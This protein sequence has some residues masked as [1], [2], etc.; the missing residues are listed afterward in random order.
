MNQ[1]TELM[2]KLPLLGLFILLIVLILL[3]F[4]GNKSF[5][6]L[7]GLTG[8]CLFGLSLTFYD[9]YATL[10]IG[11][12]LSQNSNIPP[13]IGIGFWLS[14]AYLINSLIKKYI[15]PRRLTLEGDSK[16][17]LLLQ[18]LVTLT[19]YIIAVMIIIGGVYGQSITGIAAA[20]GAVAL[21]LGYTAR[22]MV[23]EIFAGIAI[24]INAPFEKGDLIQMNEEWGFVKDIDWRT[25]TY[26]DMDNNYVVVP[27][28]TVAASK[29]RNLDRPSKMVRRTLYFRAEYNVPPKIIVEE[30]DAA[31]NECP[32]IA[33]HPWNFTSFF[34]TDETGMRYKLHFY[35]NHYDDWYVASDELFNAIWYRFARK[36]IRFAHQRHL[37][38]KNKDDE[39]KGLPDS[40]YD[41][42]NWRLLVERFNQVPMFE[43]MTS[44]DTE[45]IAK[46]AKV[47][48]VGPPEKIIRAG[49]KRTSMFLIAQGSAEVFEVDENGK[50]T[51]MAEVGVSEVLGL[52]SLLTG[53]PQRTTIRAK[54]EVVVWEIESDALHVLF[55]RKPEIMDSIAESVSRWQTEEDDALNAIAMSRQQENKLIQQ[56]TNKL[57]SRITRFFQ[58]ESKEDNEISEEYT[59][60]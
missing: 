37:N 38:F 10:I 17:P 5:S 14:V 24:N 20:S 46:S 54:S 22:S 40:A 23:E 6:V 60:Y 19:I 51:L 31:M 13:I 9:S 25:I 55:E 2:Y 48:I 57:S 41:E 36:G 33:S 53:I 21:A 34:E 52:M 42:A 30:C 8:I 39:L 32:H 27:N 7:L 59:D 12:E 44:V 58:L 1:L 35:I 4:K 45:E 29:I 28:T 56:K 50:E 16:V 18:Y 49:S 26:M 47:H 3:R 11:S 43:G 15:Y